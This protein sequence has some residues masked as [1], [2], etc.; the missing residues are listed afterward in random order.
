MKIPY[1]LGA[2]CA[3]SLLAASADAQVIQSRAAMRGQLNL[4]ST[5]EDFETYSVAFGGAENLGVL[6]LDET[7]IAN[8]Q[9]PGLV[10]DGC[11]Y[12]CSSSTL[13]WNGAGWFGQPSKNFLANTGDGRLVLTYD[14]PMQIVG[15]DMYAFSGFADTAVVT[16]YDAAGALI[17][18]SSPISVPGP[19]PVF[20]GYTAAAIGGVIVDSQ[21]YSWSTLIDDHEYGGSGPVLAVSGIC[22]GP[23]TV[24]VTGATP[25]GSVAIGYSGSTGAFTIPSGFPCAGTVLGLGGTPM[26]VTILVADGTGAAS[27][28]GSLPASVCGGSIQA[29]D[30]GTCTTSNVVPL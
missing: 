26:L 14:S 25:G 17:F 24:S 1:T 7:T 21:V 19:S 2:L 6:S 22:P 5:L 12:S 8:G 23:V 30:F 27:G 20:F 16:V 11:V 9:G 3:L 18:T 4:S 29:V 28:G 10:A 15:F 13:Q